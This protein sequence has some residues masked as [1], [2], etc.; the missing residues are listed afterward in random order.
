MP[1]SWGR[2]IGGMLRGTGIAG[3]S[4]KRRHWLRKSCC[5]N[6]D[7]DDDDDDDVFAA[8][9]NNT[10]FSLH[11]RNIL[12]A[13]SSRRRAFAHHSRHVNTTQGTCRWKTIAAVSQNVNFYVRYFHL[14]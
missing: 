12:S 8:N 11:R 3:R 6:D 5:A 1:E 7:D 14:S 13:L 9:L 10:Y 4:F 2:E